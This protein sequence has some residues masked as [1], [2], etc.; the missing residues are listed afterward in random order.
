MRI[1]IA[2]AGAIPVYRKLDQGADVSRNAETFAAV[3]AAL[4]AG[5]AVCIFP[6]GGLTSDGEIDRFRPGKTRIL[7]RT[8]VPVIPMALSGLWKSIFARNPRV[9]VPFAKLF[10]TVRLNVG[11][12][13]EAARGTPDSMRAAVMALQG[14]RRY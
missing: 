8:P 10:P 1:V 14:D 12:L 2:G 7:E 9:S 13:V 5:D 4:A 3:D 6:E 11:V